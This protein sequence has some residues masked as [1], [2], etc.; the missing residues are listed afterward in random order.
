MAY[1]FGL[2][3]QM[4]RKKAGLS[5]RE[6]G[7]RLGIT[8][9]AVGKFENNISIPSAERLK[10][11][12]YLYNVSTDYLLNIKVN[13]AVEEKEDAAR[14]R[15]EKLEEIQKMLSVLQEEIDELK[16]HYAD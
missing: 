15:L 10:Q 14:I 5:Q 11:L 3:L 8:G 1:D 7:K 16:K 2:R 9:T 4:C 12:A 6:V 13:P